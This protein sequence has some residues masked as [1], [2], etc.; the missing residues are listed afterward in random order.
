MSNRSF[1]K[2]V[3]VA[4]LVLLGLGV[5]WFVPA[6]GGLPLVHADTLNVC[7]VG[8]T[9]SSIQDAINHAGAGDT[10]TIAAGTYTE[11]LTITTDL[12]LV[13]AT[14]GNTII[15]GNNSGTVVTVDAGATAVISGVTIQHGSFTGTSG[16][17]WGG[18]GGTGAAG[19]VSNGGAL[20]LMNSVIISSTAT[21][22]T[23]AS[24]YAGGD[25]LGGGIYNTGTL[26][27]TGVT[28]AGNT[29]NGGIGGTGVLPY[30]SGGSGGTGKGGGLYNSGTLILLDS[31]VSANTA[32]GGAGGTSPTSRGGSGGSGF[33]GGIYNVG[34]IVIGNSTISSSTVAGGAGGSGNGGSIGGPGGIA[35]GGGM[36]NTNTVSLTNST[37]SENDAT[38]GDGGTG[39][40]G[41]DGSGGGIYNS[42]SVTL[43]SSP[44]TGNVVSGGNGTAGLYGGDG[45]SGYGGGIYNSGALTATDNTIS[46]NAVIGGISAYGGQGTGG[47]GGGLY[48][49]DVAALVST[50]VSDNSASGGNAALGGYYNGAAGSGL[51]G[52]IY[53]GD[54][55]AVT[56]SV[57]SSNTVSGGTAV[58]NGLGGSA[59]G[60]G[61]FDLSALSIA[62]STISA[63]TAAGGTGGLYG[64]VGGTGSGGG[65]YDLATM[66]VSESTISGNTARGGSGSGGLGNGTGGG[67]VTSNTISS[68]LQNTILAMNEGSDGP[69]DCD[70]TIVSLGYNLL[71]S[72]YGCNGLANGINGDQVGV[73]PLLGSLQDN[74]GP[75]L[76]MELMP[77]SPAIDAVAATNCIASTDQRGFP[78]PD[79]ATDDG[80]CDIGASET[81]E[82]PLPTS[83]P[84][85]SPTSTPT[86]SPSPSS[87]PTSTD[88]PTTTPTNTPVPTPAIVISPTQTSPKLPVAIT[89]TNFGPAE[90]VSVYLDFTSTPP[91]TT[92]TSTS[93]GTFVAAGIVPAAVYGPHTV[94]ALGKTSGDMATTPLTIKPRLVLTPTS[95]AP[96]KTIT[97]TALGF[98]G[99]ETVTLHWAS[100]GGPVLKTATSSNVGTAT[101]AFKVP[102]SP[103]GHYLVYAVGSTT[104]ARAS[105]S[106]TVT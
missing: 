97:A 13:G 66:T 55:L 25:G 71:G 56:S 40:N 64:G 104:K 98:G 91:L 61:I 83:T 69:L 105:A 79:E 62:N 12:A 103:A 73:D 90:Q 93:L 46:E 23:G 44:I 21:G 47:M 18:A 99:K 49:L 63:N 11:T 78:R 14:D 86:N 48:N 2:R 87:T 101:T 22:G 67:L 6:S 28:V 77:G 84:T 45:G 54:M 32:A 106:F 4:I 10:I 70:G 1:R 80:F 31:L 51:G 92:T 85:N 50:T 76:T 65:I 72:L 60:G 8:C 53:T 20:T 7:P 9:Y 52:G 100:A 34:T 15:D 74:G 41:N 94:I 26:T 19:A 82:M 89:G 24:G 17:Q 43:L 3:V 36:Y 5:S 29:A 57:I 95:G 42:G 59:T 75:T 16:D 27:L 37:V 102:Q 88:T 39:G 68:T 33:G 58:A 35:Q 30:G 38:G 96:G 81:Q